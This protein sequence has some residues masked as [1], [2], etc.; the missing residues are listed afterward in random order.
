MAL[1]TAGDVLFDAYGALDAKAEELEALIADIAR[2]QREAA[3]PA[4]PFVE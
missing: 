3:E 4:L 2:R 1:D